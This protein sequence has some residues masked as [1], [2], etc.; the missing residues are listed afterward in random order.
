MRAAVGLTVR[1][2]L[3]LR[4]LKGAILLAGKAGLDRVITS[5]NIMEVPYIAP[6]VKSNELLLT[7]IYPI[8]DDPGAQESLI[9]TLVDQGLAALAIKPVALWL[10]EVPET[11]IRQAD[12]M[13]FPLIKLPQDASF[14]EIINPILGEILNRQ[15]TI[16]KENE[17]IRRKLTQIM[18]DGGSLAEIARVV[19][20]T[21]DVPVSIHNAAMRLLTYCQP[22][23]N[24]EPTRDSATRE[25][26]S[27]DWARDLARDR[28]RLYALVGGRSGQ[29]RIEGDGQPFDIIVYPVIVAHE[30]YASLIVWGRPTALERGMMGI[31][32]QAATVVALEIAK[33]QAVGEVEKRF[34]TSFIEDL[35]QGR[36]ESRADV[37]SRGEAYGWD[38]SPGFVPML[39]EV[40]DLH[41]FYVRR[42]EDRE[43]TRALRLLWDIVSE[44]VS[45]RAPGSTAVDMSGRI[46]VLYRPPAPSADC[47]YGSSLELA[48]AILSHATPH[49][50]LSVSIGVGR[51]VDDVLNLKTGFEQARQA[52]AVGRVVSGPGSATHFDDLGVYRILADKKEKAELERFCQDFLGGLV[53]RDR[54]A[55]CDLVRTLDMVLRHWG[56]L[57]FAARQ[58][59]VHY[60]TLRYRVNLIQEITR[61]D[62]RSP[63]ARLNLQIALKI[64][65]MLKGD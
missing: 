30:H 29:L 53:E 51:Y 55:K 34:R 13:A 44:T 9:P 58:L 33:L 45:A 47:A 40:D 28:T 12:E 39:V 49:Q 31:V 23:R 32:E 19:A 22:D 37:L 14:N 11:M 59:Y 48:Q 43:A 42:N 63:E 35:I 60:N 36:I 24:G 54:R 38:L 21:L 6:F 4:A 57:K 27:E 50:P 65:H 16:L 20:S 64:L 7:T 1:E 2:A 5:V 15:A 8:R 3:E 41:Q 52:V 25:P 10:N 62:L 61:M 26:P 46:L 56:N 18:L 17:E